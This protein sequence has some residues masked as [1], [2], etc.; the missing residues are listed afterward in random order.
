MPNARKSF[1]I[2]ALPFCLSCNAAQVLSPL[3]VGVA[4]F[5][6]FKYSVA[7]GRVIGTDTEIVEQVLARMGYSAD[8]QMQPWKRV[9]MAGEIGQFAAIYS[10]T[11]TPEREQQYCFSDPI[12]TVQDVFFKLRRNQMDWQQIDDVKTMRIATSAGY[13]YAAE[14]TDAVKQKKLTSIY[15]TANPTPEIVNLRNLARGRVDLV[16]CEI[17]V[18]QFLIAR[19]AP[20]FDELDYMPKSIGPARSFHVGFS[21]KWPNGEKLCHQFNTELA[22][23]IAEGLRKKIF[24]KYRFV[25]SL[26]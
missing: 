24:D 19:H 9:Q 16:I 15:E 1:L 7:S 22:K 10:F 2:L 17:N 3:P 13:R 26:P 23:F 20:E 21:K 8:I 6:P 4:E 5:P 14:F 18:C 11:K 25:S 12:N